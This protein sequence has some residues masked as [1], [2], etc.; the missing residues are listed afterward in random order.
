MHVKFGIKWSN[1]TKLEIKT[2]KEL[3]VLVMD[4]IF[5]VC[6]YVVSKLCFTQKSDLH[7][8]IKNQAICLLHLKGFKQ[9]ALW[10]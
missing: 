1:D 5:F 4:V 2:T 8:E 6:V 7:D 10:P 3:W 9:I